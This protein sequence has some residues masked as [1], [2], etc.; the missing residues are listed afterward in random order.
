MDFN[1]KYETLDDFISSR[2]ND[3]EVGIWF[4]DNG[5]EKFI[6]KLPNH[7]IRAI[8]QGCKLEMLVGQYFVSEKTYPV[9][10]LFIYDHIDNTRILIG[11]LGFGQRE[12]DIFQA[13]L[14]KFFL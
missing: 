2:L 4:Y 14:F 11:I 7:I 3:E 6:I 10:G 8:N 9:I 5:L 12:S 13:F 1:N